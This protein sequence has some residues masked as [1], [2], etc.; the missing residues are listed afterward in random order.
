M[1]RNRRKFFTA[2]A[3]VFAGTTCGA[4]WAAT[5]RRRS[6]RW[7]RTMVADARREILTAP[8]KPT[9]GTWS[10]NKVTA[11]WLGHATVLVNF[12]GVRMLTDPVLFSRIGIRTGLGIAGPKRYIA[13][14][15]KPKELPTIDLIL[16]SH[17]HLDHLD[18]S[19][20]ARVN[21][22]ILTAKDTRDVLPSR[23]QVTEL[24]WNERTKLHFTNG[25]LEIQAIEVKHWGQRWPSE[26][27]RG[28]NGYV[29]R[30]E[31]R[32]I[33]FGGD[34]ADTR[35]EA[36]GPFDAAIMPIGAYDPWIHNHC[37]PE[38]A[39][40]MANSV[41]AN[42]I[43]PIHHQTFRL[44]KEPMNEPIERLADALSGEPERLA[45]RRVGETWQA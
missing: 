2:V 26:R 20:I 18:L 22:P 6:A 25:E 19:S 21:A 12:F 9:P 16:L 35:L 17:A 41:G 14:A 40:A 28:Y 45:I 8:A 30:R 42:Y 38:Q 3:T 10:D 37:T 31:G 32:S 29:L 39:L 4:Y 5:S 13:C 11:C 1:Q 33:L 34:T 15:L 44:S 7:I 23:R 24:G 27:E 43:V 36:R